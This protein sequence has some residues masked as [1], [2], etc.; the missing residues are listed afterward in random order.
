MR[1]P[2]LKPGA[3]LVAQEAPQDAHDPFGLLFVD[4]TNT[5]I[6]N[7]DLAEHYVVDKMFKGQITSQDYKDAIAN[8]PFTYDISIT[9]VQ[10]TTDLMQKYNVGR[11]QTPPW[12][13]SG[14]TRSGTSSAYPT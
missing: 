3:P 13:T 8:S 14:Q 7:P 2:G 4:A 10:T 5:F 11:M 12:L 1:A 6:K 9:H